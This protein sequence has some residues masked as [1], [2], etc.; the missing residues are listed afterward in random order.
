MSKLVIVESPA[1][2]KTIA[3]VLGAGYVVRA[4]L[5]HVRDLPDKELG[6]D[7]EHNFK[8]TYHLLRTKSKTLKQLRE[9]LVN[10]DELYLATD[11]DREGEAIAWHLQ[12]ALKPRVRTRRVTFH[13]ITPADIQAAFAQPR[14]IDMQLVDAQ[15]ARRVLDRLVGYQVSPLLWKSTGGKSA[16][17]VQSV[18]LRLVVDR[19]REIR[20]FVPQEYWSI[21]ADLAKQ[22]DHAQHFLA[23]LIQ[24]G[25]QKVGLDQPIHL[26]TKEDAERIIADLQGAIYRVKD[27]KTERKAR[28]PWPPFTTSTLQQSASA[29]LHLSP[30]ETMKIAQELYEGVDIGEGTPGGPPPQTGVNGQPVGLITYMLTDSTA[31]S[32]EAQAAVRQMIIDTLGAKY[33]PEAAPQYKTKVK[34]AQEAHEAIRPTDVRRYPRHLQAQLS[35]R[36]F[37]V[38]DLIWRRFVASQMAAALYDVTTVNVAATVEGKPPGGSSPPYLFRAIGRDLVFDG[39]LRVWQE[40]DKADD[41]DEPQALPPLS[42]NELLDLLALIPKQHFTQPPGRYTESALV[43]AL[44]ERGIG[45]PSTYAAIIKTLKDRDY[46]VLEKRVLSPTT[47]GEATCDALIAAFPEVMDYTF[48]AQVEDW[49][50][51]VSRGERD[52]VKALTEFYTPFALALESAA[53]KMLPFKG[54]KTDRAA[55]TFKKRSSTKRGNRSKSNAPKAKPALDPN[56]PVCPQCGSPMVKRAGPRGEFWGCSTYP[57]CK[58]TRPL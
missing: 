21:H 54:E 4:S 17:R 51:D 35:P 26:K 27:L 49:L 2:A 40:E 30:A 44:E 46:V 58:G 20:D 11:P 41:D 52:W 29:R 25:A 8:P 24:V 9:A 14:A 10:A 12:Q 53:A 3:S 18:A 56:A 57:K 7:L 1:K 34:N 55:G 5:G 42:V 45:R 31:I 23:R 13:A 33:L 36:Q 47:L 15:Q 28:K 38:Y 48:T 6:I 22:P 39:F 50:D 32:P 16:G 43:K 19:E 37:Q